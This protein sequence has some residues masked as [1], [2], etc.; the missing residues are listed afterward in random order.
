MRTMLVPLLKFEISEVDLATGEELISRRSLDLS[1]VLL[2]K[3]R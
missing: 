1:P 2:R 3:S